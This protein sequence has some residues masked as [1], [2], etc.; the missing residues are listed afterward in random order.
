MA[1][2]SLRDV[3]REGI[4]SKEMSSLVRR[5]SRTENESEV[6]SKLSENGTIARAGLA[7]SNIN[8]L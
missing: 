8:P 7:E 6:S 1:V 2:L 5:R 4:I 3:A